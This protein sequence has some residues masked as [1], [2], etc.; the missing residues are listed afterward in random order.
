MGMQATFLPK[1]VSIKE[2][3]GGEGFI[4][5][6]VLKQPEAERPVFVKLKEKADGE[7]PM[8]LGVVL[9]TGEV[10]AFEHNHQV[11][12]C[13]VRLYVSIEPDEILAQEEE[14]GGD[15]NGTVDGSSA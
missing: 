14:P 12:K 2:L 7:A 10:R 6:E 1:T 13:T 11:I 3:D 5:E 8:T 4:T 15:S 9:Q